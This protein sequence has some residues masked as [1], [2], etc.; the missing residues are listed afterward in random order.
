MKRTSFSASSGPQLRAFT[1]IELL[2]VI[3][4]ISILAAM[5]LPA[6]QKA[7][8]K[9]NAI[10]CVSNLKQLQLGWHLYAL[11][12]NDAMTPNAPVNAGVPNSWCPGTYMDWGTSDSNTNQDLYRTA[13]MAAYM[14]GQIGVY[15]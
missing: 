11:D 14:G 7:K 8:C 5:L 10:K 4:I 15:K 2:V 9:A 3:A 6:L 12:Y 13:L 1:L